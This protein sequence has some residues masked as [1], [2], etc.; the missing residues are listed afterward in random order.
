MSFEDD[1]TASEG[2]GGGDV[3]TVSEGKEGGDVGNGLSV[4]IASLSFLETGNDDAVRVELSSS[5]EVEFMK[6]DDGVGFNT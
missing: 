6:P 1:S 2:K 4:R 5:T 3:C